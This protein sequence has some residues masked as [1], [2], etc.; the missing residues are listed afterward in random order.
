MINGGHV[1][2]YSRDAEADR[3]FFRDVLEYPHVDA[4]GGWLIFKLPPA[5]VAVHPTDGPESQEL[6][7]MCDD[8]DATVSDLTAKGV[9]FTQPLTDAR[10]GRLT[11][12][13]LPGGGEVG[14]YEPRHER[15]TDL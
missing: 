4:G 7:L 9:E 5:E 6:Y 8:V 15:A 12:F 11:R 2:I 14:L 1:I 10:W 3:A 13:R